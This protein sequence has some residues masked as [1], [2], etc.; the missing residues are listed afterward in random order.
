MA[1]EEQVG[2]EDAM[3]QV[4]RAL[5]RR[6]HHLKDQLKDTDEA[7]SVHEMRVRVSELEHV[8]KIVDSLH[9]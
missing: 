6:L 5:E 3:R 9:R 8:L 4:H 7:D 1:T 2:Y